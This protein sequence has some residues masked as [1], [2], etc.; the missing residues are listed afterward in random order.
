MSAIYSLRMISAGNDICEI[1]FHRN[2]VYKR[3]D[4]SK[5]IGVACLPCMVDSM[6]R[7]IDCGTFGKMPIGD[8]LIEVAAVALGRRPGEVLL[9]QDNREKRRLA[10]K[11]G[12]GGRYELQKAITQNIGKAY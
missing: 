4:A 10:A 2:S 11:S 1:C 6:N 12:G 5:R 8:Q 9:Y 7:D 3:R